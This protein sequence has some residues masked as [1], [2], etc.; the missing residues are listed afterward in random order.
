M[1]YV[2]NRTRSS[3]VRVEDA[4]LSLAILDLPEKLLGNSFMASIVSLKIISLDFR[5]YI[6][7][8]TQGEGNG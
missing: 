7:Q 3:S 5:S 4:I 8:S 2:T 1:F 6:C